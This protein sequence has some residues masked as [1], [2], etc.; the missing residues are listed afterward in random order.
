MSSKPFFFSS[1]PSPA[2]SGLVHFDETASQTGGPYVHIGLAPK[3]AGFDIFENN[4]GNVLVA[5]E[6]RGERIDIQGHVYD[7]SGSLVRDV[8]VEVWQANADGK[9]AHPADRQAK[10]LDPSFRG[11]GRTGAD[12]ETGL[13][14]FETIKPGQVAGRNGMTQAPHI[15]MVLFARGINIGLHTRLYFSDEAEANQRDPVLTGIEWEVRRK[16][17][18][19]ERSERDGRT[20]YTFDIRLQ[21]T[22]NGGR[23]TVFFDI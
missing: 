18:I 7:G 8:L 4:F 22:P 23:E 9:Y 12:F 21:D 17:L 3:Q 13:Y 15:C 20:V 19:A 2:S 16:T 6:T 11:W 5:D 10:Q 1:H 14:R